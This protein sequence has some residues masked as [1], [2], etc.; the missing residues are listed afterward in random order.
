MGVDVKGLALITSK[1]E[2]YQALSKSQAI[3]AT[4]RTAYSVQ[5]YAKKKVRVRSGKL[6]NSIVVW[7]ANSQDAVAVVVPTAAH[8]PYVEWPTRPHIIRAR[9]KKVL[10]ARLGFKSVKIDGKSK[11][12]MSYQ[13][14]G[15]E[16]RHPGT[17]GR[18]FMG[19]AASLGRKTFTEEMEKALAQAGQAIAK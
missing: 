16:V 13:V 8:A 12:K 2:R 17:K 14:F 10:A 3:A 18:P 5:R 19:P 11:R 6:A 1:L 15:T 7:P 4:N 9:R